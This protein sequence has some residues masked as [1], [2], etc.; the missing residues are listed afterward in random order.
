MTPKDDPADQND[1]SGGGPRSGP[2]PGVVLFE[3]FN[4]IGIIDQLGSARFQSVMPDGLHV[5]HFTVLNHFA[6]L[7][8]ERSPAQ[9]ANAFQVGKATMTNTLQRLQK[10]GF[11]EVRPHPRDG[12]GKVVTIT[13]EGLAARERA[14]AALMPQI[15][16]LGQR[17]DPERFAEAL[18]FLRELRELLDRARDPDFEDG[19]PASPQRG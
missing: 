10:A 7:G 9:L 13:P 4:E 11:I 15:H 3:F 14:I 19:P 6:R 1:D 2:P 12:R 8:G 17:L 5:S 16:W 18:P